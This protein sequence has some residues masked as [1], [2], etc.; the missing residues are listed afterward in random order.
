MTTPGIRLLSI[1]AMLVISFSTAWGKTQS[2]TA[3]LSH[4]LSDEFRRTKVLLY[5]PIT[6]AGLENSKVHQSALEDP[7]WSNLSG[8]LQKYANLKLYLPEVVRDGIRKRRRYAVNRAEALER[9]KWGK[10]AY[11]E[12][13]LKS[14][15]D[16]LKSAIKLLVEIEYY[17]EDSL[18]LARIVLTLG[19]ALLEA[20]HL[21]DARDAFKKTLLI[22]PSIRMRKGFDRA[23]AVKAFEAARR[24]LIEAGDAVLMRDLLA[25]TSGKRANIRTSVRTY[26][27][28]DEAV[29]VIRTPQGRQVER[30]QRTQD[31]QA[32][33]SRLASRIFA[34][35]PFGYAPE[36]MRGRRL[37]LD[38]GFGA[39]AYANS[40]VGLVPHF[41][42]QTNSTLIVA[43][44]LSLEASLQLASSGRDH[45]EHLRK[46]LNTVRVRFGAGSQIEWNRWSL[47]GHIGLQVDYQSPVLITTTVACKY[48]SK[49]DQVPTT[50]CDFDGDFDRSDASWSV[51]GGA[52]LGARVMLAK[53][54]Y[55][56]ARA[57]TAAFAFQ[58]AANDFSLPLGV[59]ISLGY[60]LF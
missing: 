24:S 26:L 7:L 5:P 56:I 33:G 9:A 6:F 54:I 39:F 36:N 15:I 28:K 59:S 35:L 10:E 57:S 16:K 27:S 31:P 4:P 25:E 53:P 46:D 14:A 52:S 47:F 21:T 32:D 22:Q 30:L 49:E 12:V 11:G 55:L 17:Q 1:V 20:G 51:G 8:E 41:A 23:D 37:F 13:R 42:V 2:D 29:I 48:F 60:Q 58:T 45:H 44:K 50:L 18:Q 38:T 40:P 3:R 34:T 19:Q 43:D